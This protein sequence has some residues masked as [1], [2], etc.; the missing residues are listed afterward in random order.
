MLRLARMRGGLPISQRWMSSGGSGG[1]SAELSPEVVA[2]MLT[3]A[4]QG[5]DGPTATMVVADAARSG[6]LT[7]SMAN[8]GIEDC[9]E[10]GLLGAAV[11]FHATARDNEVLP[12]RPCLS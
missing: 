8:R 1:R 12:F 4:I 10:Q 6:H 5:G 9:L 2:S 11:S 7:A 3:A